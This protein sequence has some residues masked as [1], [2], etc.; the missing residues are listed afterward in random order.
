MS[1]SLAYTLSR[2]LN[3]PIFTIWIVSLPI[4][5][6]YSVPNVLLVVKTQQIQL[7]FVVKGLLNDVPCY[8]E[9]I[10]P[11]HLLNYVISLIVKPPKPTVS[12]CVTEI[13][14][15]HILLPL[16]IDNVKFT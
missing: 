8:P 13:H 1:T 7:R 16:L 11:D 4:H 9:R 6:N 5:E 12:V 2:T 10:C 15:L 3:Y 14:Y